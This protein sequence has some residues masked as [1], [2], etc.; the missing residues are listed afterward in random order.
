M[1]LMRNKPLAITAG[2]IVAAFAAW[3][4]FGFF[5][6]QAAFTETEVNEAGPVFAATE[7]EQDAVV[8]TD[9]FQDAMAEAQ[10]N[11]TESDEATEDAMP[12]SEP[13]EIVTV[14][15]GNFGGTSRYDVEGDALVL[16]DGTEQ[17]FLRL[18]NFVSDNGPDLKVYLR[19]ADDSYVDLGDLKGN[20]GDQ[21][22]EIPV[23]VNLSQFDTVQIWCE[24]FGVLF[25][26]AVLA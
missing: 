2:V 22:Y 5:G 4:A 12:D 3:L 6:I 1:F 19:A 26:D 25:G 24:R 14:V 8:E 16:N 18:E 11:P 17:R 20:I 10:E 9:E 7:A 13:A 15:S 23:D 21:N